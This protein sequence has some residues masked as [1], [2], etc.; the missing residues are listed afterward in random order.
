MIKHGYA[1]NKHR[2]P[3]Y[4]SWACMKQRCSNPDHPR[5]KDW[6]G[7]GISFCERWFTFEN[8]LADMGARPEGTSLDRWPNN[9]GNYEP[10]NCRWAT[11]DEQAE[12]RRPQRMSKRNT[13]GVK[14]VSRQ[15]NRWK[16]YVW[17]HGTRVHLGYFPTLELAATAVEN[18]RETL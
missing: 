12:T 5:Y 16:A 9:D 3:T 1:T 13:S 15:G 17:E 4:R 7:R 8:F 14:G 11:V 18:H 6:G 2:S 10:G